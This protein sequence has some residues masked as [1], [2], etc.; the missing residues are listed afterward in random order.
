V[1]GRVIL[2]ADKMTNSLNKALG[3]TERRRNI[4]K[5]HNEKHGITP[6]SIKKAIAPSMKEAESESV[7][8]VKI[9]GKRVPLSGEALQ[10][11]VDML[12]KTMKK[13]AENLEFEQAAEIRNEIHKLEMSDLGLPK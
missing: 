4:Q 13:H 8:M 11:H 3:E 6:E 12:K 1:D 7:T 9:K 10:K 5:E 2:Y